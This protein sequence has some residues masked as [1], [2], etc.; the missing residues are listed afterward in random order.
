MSTLTV[1][2]RNFL[3]TRFVA[4]LA[5]A[6]AGGVPHVVPICFAIDG[7]DCY[8]ATSDSNKRARN[9][10]ENPQ[11]AMVADHYEEDWKRIGYVLIRGKAELL[12]GGPEHEKAARL[13][14][15]RYPQFATIDPIE[16]RLV[17]A[18]RIENAVGWGVL[19]T[20][21]GSGASR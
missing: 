17:L 6:D 12:K 2:Q 18:L 13:L 1:A 7:D 4:N 19:A 16:D 11:A 14:R 10:C 3:S 20:N 9:V 8:V 5:T 15:E 21:G